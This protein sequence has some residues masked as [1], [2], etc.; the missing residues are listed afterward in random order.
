MT[1]TELKH[2][3]SRLLRDKEECEA[4]RATAIAAAA[5]SGEATVNQEE[6]SQKRVIDGLEKE[7]DFHFSKL[8]DI[9]TYIQSLVEKD[10][11]LEMAD[12]GWVKTIQDFL[13]STE[14]GFEIPTNEDVNDAAAAIQSTEE[15]PG[16]SAETEA[17]ND[18][19]AMQ[20]TQ[21]G[22]DLPAETETKNTDTAIQYTYEFKMPT[23]AEANNTNPFTQFALWF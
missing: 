18:D 2:Q 22:F 15:G 4:K 3:I 13:Y 20:S 12:D 19:A 17:K 6:E 7:R 5:S 23:G 14:E 10:P 11:E 16:L 21:D 9:E 8:Q 1:V